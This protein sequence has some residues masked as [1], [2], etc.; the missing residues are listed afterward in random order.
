MGGGVVAG[1]N[2]STGPPRA[3][4]R[5]RAQELEVAYEPAG[6]AVVDGVS[7]DVAPGEWVGLIGP[8]GSGKSTL[9]RAVSRVL[10]PRRG[11]VWVDEL[12]VTAYRRS[13]LAR[14]MAVVAQEPLPSFDFTVRDIVAMGRIPHVPPFRSETA[15]DAAAIARALERTRTDAL[16]DRPVAQLSGGER[17][18]VAIARA[19]AQEPRLLLLDEPTAHLDMG[20]Q[21]EILDLIARLVEEEG[22]SV[23][24]V[25]HD[26]NMAARYCHRLVMLAEGRVVAA[27]TPGEVITEH[28]VRDVYGVDVHV[29]VHPVLGTPWVV[30]LARRVPYAG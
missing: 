19:L 25:L 2:G 6:R 26:L 1:G 14:R 23:L 10:A 30:P 20:C 4:G 8:N 22:L 11:A 12:P 28:N 7:L 21:V 29:G 17:Q 9:L 5:L 16:A 24:S 27:G 18:R 13:A 15:R 3:S